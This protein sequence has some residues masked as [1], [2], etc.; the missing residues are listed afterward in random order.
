MCWLGACTG[1]ATIP[2]AQ[3]SCVR[4]ADINIFLKEQ[5]RTIE[6]GNRYLS[7]DYFPAAS[8]VFMAQSSSSRILQWLGAA[9]EG[10][11]DGALFVL[12]CG[13]MVLAATRLEPVT[14]LTLG[15][16]LPVGRTVLVESNRRVGTG[17]LTGHVFLV[18]LRGSSIRVLWSFQVFESAS[19]PSLQVEYTDSFRW[20]FSSNHLAIHVAGERTVGSYDDEEHG[21]KGQT[22]HDLPEETFCWSKGS[23]AYENCR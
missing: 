10:P 21:W 4:P 22:T 5:S 8:A 17:V 19:A 15:P 1:G 11:D 3:T 23:E 9:W 16:T 14:R 6:L 7:P 18:A 12:D 13:G 2:F 20:N